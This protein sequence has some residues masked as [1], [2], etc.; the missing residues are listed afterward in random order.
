MVLEVA[1]VAAALSL[2]WCSLSACSGVEASLGGWQDEEEQRDGSCCTGLLPFDHGS[3]SR[4]RLNSPLLPL[5]ARLW[6]LSSP[7]GKE[8]KRKEERKTDRKEER[9]WQQNGTVLKSHNVILLVTNGGQHCLFSN[10][11]WPL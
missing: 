10:S 8:R 11:R 4:L 3:F 1:A 9:K 2:P 6:M 7:G 5:W